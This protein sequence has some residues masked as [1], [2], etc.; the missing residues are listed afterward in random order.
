MSQSDITTLVKPIIFREYIGIGDDITDF[1]YK[2]INVNLQNFHFILGFA[3]DTYKEGKGTGAF[4]ASWNLTSFSP[5]KVATL[6]GKYHNVKVV[7]SIGGGNDPEH[8]FNPRDN[9]E[10]I[11]NAISS[12]KEIILDYH[13]DVDGIDINYEKITSSVNDF[14]Y[15]IGQVIHQLK[16]DSDVSKSMNTVSIAPT[17]P[18]QPHYLKLYQDNKVNID[19]INYKFYDQYFPS[20]DEFVSLFKK[21]VTDTEYDTKSKLLAGVSTSEPDKSKFIIEG[22]KKLLSEK[23]LAGFFVWNTKASA[24]DYT[25]EGVLQNLLTKN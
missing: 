13:K 19:W 2:I 4:R 21:L 24:P 6:K 9:N 16:A 7:I 12:I 22:C 15:C 11:K 5:E 17:M 3:T 8:D 18:L 20:S 25:T 10:W 23:S 14:S 1:P